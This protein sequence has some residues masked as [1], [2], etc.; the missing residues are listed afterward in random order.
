MFDTTEAVTV[1]PTKASRAKAEERRRIDEWLKQR[2]NA[3]APS[4]EIA[5]LTPV[6]AEALL[7]TNV[8]NRPISKRN[9]R[10]LAADIANDRYVFNGESIVISNTGL[11]LDG[12]HRCE[13]V[14][15]TG[16]SIQT[17]I[18]FGV[19]ESARFTIDTGKSKTASNF[20]AMKGRQYHGILAAV[21]NYHLQ[22]R[23]NNA[24]SYTGHGEAPTKIQIVTAAD[25]IPGVD[26]SIAFA[27]PAAKT[28]K[29]HAVVAFCHYVIWKKAGREVADHFIGKL[30]SGEGLR[31]F[32][33]I[34]HCRNRLMNMGRGRIAHSRIE[35]IFR[36]W[37]LH[38][39]G[40]RADTTVRLS[41][42]L[43]KV[44]R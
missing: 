32:D 42:N 23:T 26:D 22:W 1:E 41:G 38:R 39:M 3:S 28:I 34:L 40:L 21:V 29:N 24:I 31:K 17:V 13:Q 10:D 9:A 19:K 33:P 7:A 30:I 12:Q 35:L 25:E 16:K 43:P 37:N 36:C 11:L 6:M 8:N 14:V 20:L 15:K 44:E 2:W 5:T 18:V 4:A 27:A